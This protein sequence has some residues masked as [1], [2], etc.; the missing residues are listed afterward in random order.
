M[1]A[2]NRQYFVWRDRCAGFGEY[3]FTRSQS[4]FLCEQD[5]IVVANYAQQ[6]FHALGVSVPASAIGAAGPA[7]ARSSASASST[8][9][10]LRN[11]WTLSCE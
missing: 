8:A 10:S 1:L 3:G 6:D 11:L 7:F 5:L 9:I 4:N 2:D